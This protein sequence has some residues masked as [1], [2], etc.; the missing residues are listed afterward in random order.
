MEGSGE[1]P[2]IATGAPPSRPPTEGCG[3]GKHPVGGVDR[4]GRRELVAQDPL[5]LGRSSA[6]VA[7]DL[8]D[9]RDHRLRSRLRTNSAASPPRLES[10]LRK[11]VEN[12]ACARVSYASVGIKL[13]Q[14]VLPLIAHL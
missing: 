12:S 4:R 11:A 3:R 14:H 6:S 7:A 10:L 13:A 9:S 1:G 2:G 8:E 5:D